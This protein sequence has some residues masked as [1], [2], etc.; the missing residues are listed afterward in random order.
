MNEANFHLKRAS[1]L[2]R[3]TQAVLQPP[4]HLIPSK[5]TVPNKNSE[6]VFICAG[7]VLISNRN[8]V[9]TLQDCDQSFSK[10]LTCVY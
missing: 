10:H 3:G 7:S 5:M 1:Y 8:S 2:L 6:I 9:C 4:H